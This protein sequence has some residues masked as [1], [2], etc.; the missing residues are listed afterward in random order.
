MSTID[1]VIFEFQ[2]KLDKY[3]ADIAGAQRMTDQ[4]LAAIEARG[5]AFGQNMKK[6][7]SLAAVSASAFVATLGAQQMAQVINGALKAAQAVQNLSQ[8]ANASVEDFQRAAYAAQSVGVESEKLA[9]IY[10]DVNDK[11]GEFISTGG[12]ELKDF[13]DNIAPKVGVTADQFARLSGPEALQ[14]YVSSLE[15]AGVNQQQMTFYMEALADE[16][17]ALLPLLRNGGQGMNQLADAADRLGIVLS[18]DQIQR[19]GETAAKLNDIKTV[20]EARI[21]SAVTDNANAIISLANAFASV[22][23]WA[24]KAANAY[25]RFKLEQGVRL[26]E[27]VANGWATTEAEKAKARRDADIYRYELAKMDGTVD[28]TGSFRDYRLAGIDAPTGGAVPAAASSSSAR[29]GKS[30]GRSGPSAL[31]MANRAAQSE[32]RYQDELA[33]IRVDRLRAEADYTGSIEQ[34]F[35]AITA[36]LEEELKSYTRQVETDDSIDATKRARLISEKE[37]A[38]AAERRNA[39]QERERALADR[40]SQLGI[41]E[42]R[43]QADILDAKSRL[44]TGSKDRLR[45]ELE[46]FD[47]QDRLRKAE[48]DRILATEATAS[49]AWQAAKIERDTIEATAG[50]RRKLVERQNAS[51]LQDY[52]QKLQDTQDNLGDEAE[53]L[54]ISELEQVRS[55]MRGALSDLIGTDDPLLTGLIDLLVQDLIIKPLADALGNAGG[56]GGIG[57]SI[58]AG[59]GAIFGRASGGYV[60]PGQMVRVNEGAS[61]G[62]V[63]GWLPSGGGKVIPL[64]QMDAMKSQRGGKVFNITVDA[65]NSVTPEGFARDLSGEI[66]RQAAAMDGQVAQA[67]VKNIPSRMAQYERDGQ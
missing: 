61:K 54:I 1:P 55:S 13:F 19:A 5:L 39:V 45:F 58:I 3:R 41:A 27:N 43:A 53:K 22:V 31:E 44:A 48:L 10:K 25:R 14:L 52:R 21:A 11:I 49:S 65:R 51:P 56:G 59:I 57:G 42:L 12:G 33:R 17:T 63:E 50:D 36:A 9:D 40:A 20:L 37:A 26:S 38:I 8:V 16:A 64:G 4:K 30:G 47:L 66:L 2:A 29:G 18:Q 62:R 34:Q 60:A 15:K 24:G 32:A 35:A 7:F 67:V 46:M 6:G 28:K 23:D